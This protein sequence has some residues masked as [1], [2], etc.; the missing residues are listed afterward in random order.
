MSHSCRDGLSEPPPA[1]KKRNTVANPK[2]LMSD[3]SPSPI[4]S[5][6]TQPSHTIRSKAKTQTPGQTNDMMQQLENLHESA[7]DRK[8]IG[9][10]EGQRVKL[11]NP[12][13]SATDS[14]KRRPKPPPPNFEL[15]FADLND[16]PPA[17]QYYIPVNEDD[18][19]DLPDIHDLLNA[20]QPSDVMAGQKKSSSTSDYSNSEIDALIRDI[21]LNEYETG[22]A[23]DSHDSWR[24]FSRPVTPLPSRKRPRE[25]ENEQPKKRFDTRIDTPSENFTSSSP[26]LQPS[27]V[28][29]STCSRS[30]LMLI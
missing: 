16:S 7:K 30:A 21:P 6:T 29:L 8:R 22:L 24:P 20:Y 10:P 5:H 17:S 23:D 13:V 25:P 4:F 11:N 1:P 15:K 18:D 14:S 9:I 27:K 2:H 3:K 19:E 12:S 26:V 28:C